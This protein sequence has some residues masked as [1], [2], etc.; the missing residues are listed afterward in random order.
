MTTKIAIEV[1]NIKVSKQGWY[2][3]DY[4]LTINGKTKKGQ[5][6]G[7]YSSQTAEAFRKVLKRGWAATLV[8]QEHF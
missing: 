8:L 3:F 6:D 2:R 4:K 7:S 5:A 1:S